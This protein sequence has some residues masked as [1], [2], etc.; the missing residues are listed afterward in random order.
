MMGY[1]FGQMPELHFC[2]KCVLRLRGWDVDV[3]RQLPS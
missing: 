1:D 3:V 2:A